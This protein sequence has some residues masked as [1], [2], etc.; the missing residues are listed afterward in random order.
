MLMTLHY[1]YQLE[2]VQI[3]RNNQYLLH[4]VFCI[5]NMRANN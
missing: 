4:K 5:P 1:N 3:Y 2:T